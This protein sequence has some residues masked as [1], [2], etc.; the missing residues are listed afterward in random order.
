MRCCRLSETI[1]AENRAESGTVTSEIASRDLEVKPTTRGIRRTQD[2]VYLKQQGRAYTIDCR[3]VYLFPSIREVGLNVWC[4]RF[5]TNTQRKLASPTPTRM[6][7]PNMMKNEG[8]TQ[9]SCICAI[10]KAI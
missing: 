10:Y 7:L 6:S 8:D 4:G 3:V 5:K 2:L 1:G 9:L